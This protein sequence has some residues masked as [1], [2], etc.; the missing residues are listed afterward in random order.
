MTTASHPVINRV[1]LTIGTLVD[2]NTNFRLSH[3]ELPSTLLTETRN[4]LHLRFMMPSKT[5][6]KMADTLVNVTLKPSHPFPTSL[7]VFD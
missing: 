7:A 1:Q 2:T 3:S 4:G 5:Q 6:D